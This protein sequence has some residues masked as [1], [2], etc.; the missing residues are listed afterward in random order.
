MSNLVRLLAEHAAEHHQQPAPSHKRDHTSPSGFRNHRG[1]F[2][3]GH[4][5][6]INVLMNSPPQ[7]NV[8]QPIDR[9]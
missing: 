8:P 1:Q 9:A 4:E 2:S 7:M 3:R 5:G 6:L